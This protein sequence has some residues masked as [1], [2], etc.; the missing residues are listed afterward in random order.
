MIYKKIAGVE[1]ND[2]CV[3]AVEINGSSKAHKVSAI[4]S[5]ELSENV[6][7]DGVIINPDAA[8][9]VLE[10]LWKKFSF[11]A[12]E[13]VFGVDN[14]YV[15]VRYADIKNSKDRKF[16]DD[17]KDQIQ[18]F[19]PVDQTTVELD[20]LALSEK[21]DDDG[22]KETR[23]LIVAAG[24]KMLGEYTEIF[25]RA[26]LRLLDIDV[27]T[28]AISRLLTKEIESDRGVLVIN[29]KRNLMNL[30]VIRGETPLLARNIVIDTSMAISESEFVQEYFEAISKDI[31]SSLAYYNSMTNDYIEKIF[32]TGYGVWNEGMVQF[33]KESTKADVYVINPF[34]NPTNKSGTPMVNRPYEYAVAYSLALRG[35]ESE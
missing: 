20:Y 4:G 28:L 9:A 33:L 7:T 23:T 27:N 11:K 6:I 18:Q 15:L 10:E 31:V 8:C 17:V 14:K 24:K 22:N 30:L 32:I 29:F 26:K 1:F 35:L 5:I 21:T 19:L 2:D 12:K 3:R 16:A 13:V 25:K 34:V